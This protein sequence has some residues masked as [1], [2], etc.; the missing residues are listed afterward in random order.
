M[1]DI[2]ENKY[3]EKMIQE[4]F[5]S[6]KLI[7]I[8]YVTSLVFYVI[9]LVFIFPKY[10][11][12]KL[13]QLKYL[14][15]RKSEVLENLDLIKFIGNM[16]IVLNIIENNMYNTNHKNKRYKSIEKYKKIFLRHYLVYE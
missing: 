1:W 12:E 10:Q 5:E 6:S 11:N 8:T 7:V 4:G 14:S 2:S 9:I 13:N 3:E 16:R 15:R